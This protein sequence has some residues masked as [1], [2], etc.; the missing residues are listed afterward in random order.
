M[1]VVIGAIFVFTHQT[2]VPRTT[3]AVTDEAITLISAARKRWETTIPLVWSNK[4]KNKNKTK[5]K[6]TTVVAMSPPLRLQTA[7]HVLPLLLPL[8]KYRQQRRQHRRSSRS[9]SSRAV[10]MAAYYVE[11]PCSITLVLPCSA[12]GIK[13]PSFSQYAD[14]CLKL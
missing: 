10:A 9:S 13:F 4:N 14:T 8:Q 5:T 6:S 2:T 3:A 7:T 11:L 12:S 1:V